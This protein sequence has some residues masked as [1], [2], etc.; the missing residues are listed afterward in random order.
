MLPVMLKPISGCNMGTIINKLWWIILLLLAFSSFDC[1]LERKKS[2]PADL[3]NKIVF[4][5]SDGICTINSDGTDLKVIVPSAEGGP[6]SNPHWSTDKRRIAFNGN[7]KGSSRIMI[8][9]NDGSD[10]KI[11]GL[12][13]PKSKNSKPGEIR[14]EWGKYDLQFGDWSPSGKYFSYSHGFLGVNYG[15]VMS[16]DG[17]IKTELNGVDFSFAGEH[18]IMFV[19]WFISKTTAAGSRIVRW[20]LKE[21]KRQIMTEGEGAFHYKPVF[22]SQADRIA[23]A[24]DS[25]ALPNELWIMNVN[26]SA[27]KRLASQDDFVG[28]R[29]Q[30]I[31]F[32][33]D[34]EKILFLPDNGDR[35]SIYVV[36]NDGTGLHVVVGDIVN[37][38]GGADWSP[39]G[40]EIIFTSDKDGNQELYIVNIEGND[41]KRLTY[42]STTDCCPDW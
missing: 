3:K 33:P 9:D 36:N 34:G 13:R 4:L 12:P 17:E 41:L 5:C 16:T 14:V 27:K 39:D 40:K 25:V 28:K 22:S 35:S 21:K 15:G 24:V 23:Y 20:D 1:A 37:S 31:E 8:V 7:V 19:E 6:F 32:S 2:I 30:I 38:G 11:L 26:G 10:S 29:L 18:S 42:N